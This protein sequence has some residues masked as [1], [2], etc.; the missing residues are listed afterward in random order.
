VCD[1]ELCALP[2]EACA[3]LNTGPAIARDFSLAMHMHRR[4]SMANIDKGSMRYIVDPRNED[5]EGGYVG[6]VKRVNFTTTCDAFTNDLQ[7]S[8][9]EGVVG[10]DHI[11][12]KAEWQRTI[13][14][15]S[16]FLYQGPGPFLCHMSP[17]L[18][19][20]LNLSNCQCVVLI[21]RAENEVSERRQNKL[22]TSILPAIVQLRGQ[23]PAPCLALFLCPLYL[24]FPTF[25]ICVCVRA[26]TRTNARLPPR[27]NA[28]ARSATLCAKFEAIPRVDAEVLQW[29]DAM[30]AVS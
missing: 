1:R 10:S 13:A 22:D 12:S 14:G 27:T 11:P 25:P 15:G 3:P 28:V 8:F 21:D 16:L 5:V 6:T 29:R 24:L 17:G 2:L 4:G 18:L 23:R 7:G 26:H 30:H 9:S 19:S 20:T